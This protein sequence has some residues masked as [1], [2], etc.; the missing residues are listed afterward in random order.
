VQRGEA[1]VR[2]ETRYPREG[3]AQLT[4]TGELDVY[5]SPQLR[6]A[7]AELV[8]GGVTALVVDISP[9]DYLDSTGLGVLLSGMRRASVRD[10]ELRVVCGDGRVR[11]TFEITGLT[12]VFSLYDSAAEALADAAATS[13][14]A[15]APA[16]D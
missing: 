11:R 13:D 16:A 10:V 15:G 2:I 1:D 6:Q 5:S 14:R 8:D 9:V 3:V 12:S 4:V 7:L